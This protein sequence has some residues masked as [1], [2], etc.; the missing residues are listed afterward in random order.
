MKDINIS[1]LH[2]KL[3]TVERRIHY[4]R[5]MVSA[6]QQEHDLNTK[7]WKALEGERLELTSVMD[8]LSD[9]MFYLGGES[10]D[11]ETRTIDSYKVLMNRED[12]VMSEHRVDLDKLGEEVLQVR[13]DLF[14]LF[15]RYWDFINDT[16]PCMQVFEIM[17]DAARSAVNRFKE[18]KY[19][20]YD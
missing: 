1:S 15:D 20:N 10:E 8:W 18:I 14:R 13:I 2:T 16:K 11:I 3:A 4:I 9:A 12:F 5:T 19:Y 6:A 7:L 17:I